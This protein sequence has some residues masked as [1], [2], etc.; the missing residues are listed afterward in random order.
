MNSF[1]LHREKPTNHRT[2]Q[3]FYASRS[4]NSRTFCYARLSDM[5]GGVAGSQV[6]L[7][8]GGAATNR[9]PDHQQPWL[10]DGDN[11]DKFVEPSTDWRPVF[12]LDVRRL[13]VCGDVCSPGRRSERKFLT[14]KGGLSPPSS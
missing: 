5:A 10:Y 2:E 1:R 6:R 8:C 13:V 4:G 9:F 12:S 14:R 3:S 11:K 7:G